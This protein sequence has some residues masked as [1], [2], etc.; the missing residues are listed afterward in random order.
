M[1]TPQLSPG[2][3]LS[4]MLLGNRVQQAI[5]VAAKLGV[6]DQLVEGPRPVEELA[7]ATG[8]HAGALRRL[9]RVLAG[10]G[11]FAEDDQGR[12]GLTPIATLL[13]SGTR[14]SKRAFALWSGGV[15][16]QLFGALDH[17]V[18]TGRP[19]FEELFGMEFFEYLEQNP[20]VGTLF[21]EFMSR[22]TA[23][24]GPVVAGYDFSGVRSVVDVAGGR[25]ELLAAIL[26]ANP[27][28]RGILVDRPRAIAAA[29]QV[30][31]AAGVARRC[32]MISADYTS[33]VPAGGDVYILKSI[34]HGLDDC[35]AIDLLR[36]CRAGMNDGAMLLLV[37]FVMPASG[38]DPF[39]GRLMDLLMLIG[40]HGGYER[41]EAEFG[42]LF[43]A[44][45][46][47]L[48]NI[49]TTKY[50]YSVI[51]GRAAVR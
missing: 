44:A 17:S 38:N 35:N 8:S 20:E 41:T 13:R 50:Q 51:E 27:T 2:R 34:V 49:L 14:E 29:A 36:N 22:Q 10:F 32:T 47:E 28:I 48:T 43:A 37:E 19:A 39:P 30:M 31:Q 18:V 23:P 42:K 26:L 11:V 3:A 12:F 4:Q 7:D 1:D 25:G 16:Y 21:D 6:A 46:F 15:S 9:L 5:Y 33:S 45:G 24:V 40:S